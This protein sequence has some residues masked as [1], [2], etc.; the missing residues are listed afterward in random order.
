MIIIE[1]SPR[2]IKEIIE[3]ESTPQKE[4]KIGKTIITVHLVTKE[5]TKV[6]NKFTGQSIVLPPDQVD[7]YDLLIGTE[8]MLNGEHPNPFPNLP[9][10]ELEYL[11]KFQIE[12]FRAIRNWFLKYNSKA[13]FTLID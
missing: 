1:G 8:K 2:L 9:A 5:E 12:Q 6:T 3:Q 13:Y 11:K 7:L 4:F 10:V